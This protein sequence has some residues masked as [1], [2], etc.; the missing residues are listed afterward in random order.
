VRHQIRAHLSYLGHPV[1]G[2]CEY[3]ARREVKGLGE[4]TFLHAWQIRLPH[5][6]FG[7]PVEIA[8]PLPEELLHILDALGLDSTSSLDGSG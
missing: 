7:S 6:L 8:C 1:V 2:D 3:K 5:P 4:R